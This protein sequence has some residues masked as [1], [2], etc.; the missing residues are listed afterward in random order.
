[1][2]GERKEGRVVS[3]ASH[4]HFLPNLGILS[5]LV[6]KTDVL[7]RYKGAL[8]CSGDGLVGVG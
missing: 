7:C 5:S 6:G 1:M 8:G 4:A 2:I 3:K